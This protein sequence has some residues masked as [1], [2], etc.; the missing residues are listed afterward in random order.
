MCFLDS[1]C[2]RLADFS[3]KGPKARVFSSKPCVLSHHYSAFQS[4][5]RHPPPPVNQ[6]GRVPIICFFYEY[7]NADF[8]ELSWTRKHYLLNI[9]FSYLF[10]KS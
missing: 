4:G 9:V 7:Q 1:V 5:P 6:C 8:I 3:S 10:S 2:Q